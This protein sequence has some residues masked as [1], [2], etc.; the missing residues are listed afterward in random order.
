MALLADYKVSLIAKI[1]KPL[2]R[3]VLRLVIACKSYLCVFRVR[4]NIPPL[5]GL[6]T[7]IAPFFKTILERISAD[8]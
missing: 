8:R 4:L 7:N 1:Y 2:L 6:I 5:A 3:S